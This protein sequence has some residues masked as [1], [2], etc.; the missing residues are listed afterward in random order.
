M[1]DYINFVS[2]LGASIGV[3]ELKFLNKDDLDSLFPLNL[4][5]AKVMLRE[6]LKN[7]KKD[8]VSVTLVIFIFNN[9]SD[10]KLHYVKFCV[11]IY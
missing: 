3:E 7:W 6:K 5:G 10:F 11:N 1:I 2:I 8:S 9:S 4:L